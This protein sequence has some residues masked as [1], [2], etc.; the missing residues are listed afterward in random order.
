MT[1]ITIKG[2]TSLL[3]VIVSTIKY[4]GFCKSHWGIW[5][6][7]PVSNGIGYPTSL[8]ETDFRIISMMITGNANKQISTQ[9]KIPLSTVQRRT[10]NIIES[11]LV[12][13]KIEPNFKRLGIK[14]GLL[15]LYLK[16]GNSKDS[17][18]NVAK[19]DGIL[20]TSVHVGNSDVV[21][22]F[23]YEDSEQ[24]VDTI[25]R[26]KHMDGV[27]RVMWSEEVYSVPVDSENVLSSFKRFWSNNKS[28][29]KI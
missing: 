5:H 8:D 10:R 16:N 24:L 27:D 20:S 23:V 22:D 1:I 19:M 2:L 6:L 25:S 3:L 4:E 9:L 18:M 28:K 14:K 11:G 15:H 12:Q 7:M 17:A 21:S 29:R 26:M 13:T